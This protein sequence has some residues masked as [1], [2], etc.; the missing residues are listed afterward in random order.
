MGTLPN[1]VVAA[2]PKDLDAQLE[3]AQ[4]I[5]QFAVFGRVRKLEEEALSLRS[6]ISEK[7]AVI[8]SLQARVIGAENTFTETTAKLTN[9]MEAQAKLIEDKDVLSAQVMKLMCQVSKLDEFRKALTKSLESST[10]CGDPV[11]EKKRPCPPESSGEV[12]KTTPISSG[13]KNAG[14]FSCKKIICPEC[15]EASPSSIPV[16]VAVGPDEGPAES[17]YNQFV[18]S[19]VIDPLVARAPSDSSCLSAKSPKFDGKEFFRLV[20]NRLSH[21]QF[22]EFLIQ[23]KELNAHHQSREKFFL[24]RFHPKNSNCNNHVQA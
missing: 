1:S 15:P 5:T 16:E 8:G 4:Q 21:E 7:D 22:N 10:E 20:R 9:A 14:A 6:K 17:R 23:I 2:L 3:V 12:L 19:K 24:G 13:R 18:Y 11:E